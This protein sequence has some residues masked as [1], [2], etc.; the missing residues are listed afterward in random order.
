MAKILKQ[1]SNCHKGPELWAKST[2]DFGNF[3]RH[4]SC[5]RSAKILAA[6]YARVPQPMAQFVLKIEKLSHIMA[7]IP[8]LE[9]ARLR[10]PSL[11]MASGTY[12]SSKT[13]RSC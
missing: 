10:S 12:L 4:F 13:I 9:M 1:N 5:V 6:M 2:N 8:I 11:I 3:G 7:P